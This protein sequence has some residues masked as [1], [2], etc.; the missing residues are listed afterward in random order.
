M[1]FVNAL[2]N[3]LNTNVTENGLV[4]YKSTDSVLL[5]FNY[6]VPSMR[7]M[8]DKSLNKEID[9]L[10]DGVEDREILFR[11][12]FY[13]RDVR[14]GMGER[15]VFRA[16]IKR[17]AERHMKEVVQLIPLIAEYGRFDDLFVLKDTPYEKDMV[18]FVTIILA[19]DVHRIHEGKSITLLAKWMPSENASSKETKKLARFFRERFELSSKDYRMF[20]SDLRDYSNVVEHRISKEEYSKINYE[21]VPSKANLRYG[22][23]FLQ[24][25]YKRREEFLKSLEKGEAKVK[26]QTLYPSDVVSYVRSNC[27]HKYNGQINMCT[28]EETL[29]KGMWKGL[30]DFGKIGNTLVVVDVSGSMESS[31]GGKVE[32]LDV[33][34]GLGMYFAERNTAPFKDIVVTFSEYPEMHRLQSGNVVGNVSHMLKMDWGMNTNVKKVFE[35]VLDTAKKN[36]CSQEDIPEILIISDM[37]FDR[38]GWA[39][40]MYD[41]DNISEKFKKAGY[42]LPRLTFWNVNSRSNTIPMRENDNGLVLVSGFSPSSIKAVM[43]GE[44]DPYK[45]LLACIT[46]PRY[47]RVVNAIKRI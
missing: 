20:L 5:D 31:V 21:S 26:S 10:L 12:I 41:F 14:G 42:K 19:S 7:K 17:M 36:N 43:S 39:R 27:I 3:E 13:L 45:A 38:C 35:L 4:G 46:V 28:E 32:A 44:L 40:Y 1:D 47:D 29:A 25:D 9:K 15:R 23:L 33:S 2:K 37:E 22:K 8:N 30:K 34:L 24:K 6:K 18:D 11:Y 16:I